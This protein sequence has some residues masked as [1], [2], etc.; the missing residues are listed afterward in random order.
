MA[1]KSVKADP[2]S[3]GRPALI[4]TTFWIAPTVTI[5]WAIADI[6]GAAAAVTNGVLI[7][8][9]VCLLVSWW[10]VYRHWQTHREGPALLRRN[11]AGVLRTELP[12]R[13]LATTGHS[14]GSLMKPGPPKK[15]RIQAAGLPPMEGDTAKKVLHVISELTEQ[16]FIVN[17]KKSKPGKRIV[18]K[19]KPEEKKIVLT[20]RQQ[21]EQGILQGAK[22][23]FPKNEPKVTCTWDEKHD[24]D[25]LLDVT[26]TGV[27]G[28]ELA[29][30]GKRRQVLMKLRTRI[31]KGNFT[32]DVDPSEDAIYFQRSRPLP[33]VVV[34][35]K[36]HAPLL[37]DHEAYTKFSVPLG[38]GDNDAQ[39]VWHPKKDAHLLIIGGTG[40]GKT[41]AEH[42]VIQRLTQAGWRCWLVDG[43]RIEFIGYRDWP[44]VEML[45]QRVD[46]QIRVLKAAHE[47]M[48]ARYDLIERGE[49]RIEDLDPI[50][51]V[52]DELT[53]LLGAVKRRY[54]ESKI[55]KM[56]A[57][58][59]VLEWVADI[60]RL[61]RSAKMH[62]VLGL[63]RPDASIMGGEMRDNFGCRISLG[64][65]QSK[66]ASMMMWDDPAIGVSVPNIKGRAIADING[67]PGMVQ[68]TFTANPDPNHDDYKP[69][70]VEA[71][72]P[73]VEAYTRK[74]IADPEVDPTEEKVTWHTITGASLLD[75][76]GNPVEF[77]PVS[78]DESQNLRRTHT[79]SPV[80]D[81][82][83]RLQS[84]ESLDDALALFPY[85]PLSRV[86]FGNQLARKL[87]ELAKELGGPQQ[88][89]ETEDPHQQADP[90]GG[91]TT[92]IT[93]INTEALGKSHSSEV[94]YIEPGQSVVIDEVG[95]DE[96]TVSSCEA[97]SE[98]PEVYYLSG[99]A[100][101]E[102]IHVELS[103]DTTVEIFDLE[104]A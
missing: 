100:D 48:E 6:A 38:I 96:I 98:D 82:N 36:D 44:N 65:L 1:T 94:R 84:G 104:T 90:G 31:P 21:V 56:P 16:D 86:V 92:R 103:A 95:G 13:S 17:A 59:P 89:A 46:H 41:I 51:I 29:Q 87:N 26:I 8:G 15:I 93:G 68:G 62:L 57:K 34:P 49:A 81:A 70:M 71:M 66:E 77:D 91:H 97:D 58:D 73:T 53:S 20:P 28:M 102:A 63:Q 47:T 42:G 74:G 55:T 60:A 22:D 18:L 99:Y 4:N 88:Q 10:L 25:Y 61:G 69:G 80:T 24:E 5:L 35:A 12:P 32:S 78:S 39:A 27:N 50:A 2:Y 83:S 3:P 37:A 14:F 67:V 75:G 11:L 79:S 43:K 23:L 30:S 7:V 76:E 54:Q 33:S 19:K 101:G 45:A 9:G 72:R 64:K 85:D 40:G 52:V